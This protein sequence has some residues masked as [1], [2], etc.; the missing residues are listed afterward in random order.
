MNN[1]RISTTLLIFAVL[2][3]HAK[4]GKAVEANLSV[5]ENMCFPAD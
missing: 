4:P 3:E 1:R 2:G 5:K